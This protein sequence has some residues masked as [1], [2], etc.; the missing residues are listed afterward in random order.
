MSFLAKHRTAFSIAAFFFVVIFG[1]IAVFWARGFKPNLQTGQIDRTGLIVANSTPTGANVYLDDRLTSA[2]NTSIA[3]LDP[4]SYKVR[5]EKEGY[6]KWEKD[7]GVKA[8]LATEINALLFPLAPEIKPLTSTGA[9]S[10]TLAPDNSK[11]VYGVSGQTGGVF[12]MPLV[13]SPFA[14]RQNPKRLAPNTSSIDYSLAKFIWNPNSEEI[15][16]RIEDENGQV[17]ANI[18]LNSQNTDQPTRDITASLNATLQSWQ[19]D[20]QTQSQNLAILA[21]DQIKQSTAEAGLNTSSSRFTSANLINYYPN[22]LIFSPDEKRILYLHKDNGYNVYDL[23]TKENFTL[24][25]FENLFNISWYH[26][27][28][29]LIIAQEGQISIIEADGHNKIP[30]FTG[31]FVNG[32]VFSHPA[33]FRLIVLSTLTQPAGTPANLYSINLK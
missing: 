9:A 29:H 5:I 3:F 26:N 24:G 19:L 2:T 8:D 12:L 28:E 33:G 6:S 16:A 22:G 15:I 1:I 31:T 27:S 4:G 13:D 32:F 7:I 18:L 21:P 11:L 14:F 20:L 17:I 25:D 10:P 23:K 30:V